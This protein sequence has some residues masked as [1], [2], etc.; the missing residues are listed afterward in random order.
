MLVDFALQR[1]CFKFHGIRCKRSSFIRQNVSHSAQLIEKIAA[2]NSNRIEFLL[3]I[4]KRLI[5]LNRLSL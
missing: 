5:S 4:L 3:E 1:E 2:A